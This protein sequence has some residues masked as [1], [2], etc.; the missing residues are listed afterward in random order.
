MECLK[1]INLIMVFHILQWNAR[2][3]VAN[4]QEFKK[5]VADLE[6]RPDVMC[7][8]ETWLRPHLDFVISGYSS[9]RCDRIGTQGGGCITFIKDTLAYRRITV[10]NEYE[11]IVIEMC[12]PRGNIKVVNFYNPCKKLSKQTF[13][14]ISE[15]VDR[16]EIWCGDFNAHNT[17]WGS[18]YTDTNGEVVE[19]LIE[20][21]LLACLNDGRGTRVNVTRNSVS[22][23]DLTLVS[24]NM[25]N[26]CEWN[27]KNDNNIGSD[28]FPILCSMNFDMYV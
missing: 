21:R 23:I 2:S 25:S 5:V 13:H 3:L 16:R 19:E 7:I 28:H 12:S 4:G 22:C 14:E 1:V 20:E 8:Q 6:V 17:L 9:V 18:D 24:V 11:C 27:V 26:L 10:P 15:S